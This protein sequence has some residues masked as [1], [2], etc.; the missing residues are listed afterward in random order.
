M[1][2]TITFA[3]IGI[4]HSPYHDP[5]Q[6]PRQPSEANGVG[7]TV[8]IFPEYTEGLSDLDG[9]SHIILVYYFLRAAEARLKVIPSR[10]TVPRGI[11]ATRSP[12]R[13]NP[14][15]LSI[16]RLEQI[17][18]NTLYVHN[19]DIIDGTPLLDIKPY[20]PELSRQRG[21]KLG[22]LEKVHGQARKDSGS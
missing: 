2:A 15:G 20:L 7:G 19:L 13:P 17:D 11:F 12:S 1:T 16:V 5:K 6:V 22:W 10:D 14:I 9:F 18:G 8:E 21:A 3:P 4:I